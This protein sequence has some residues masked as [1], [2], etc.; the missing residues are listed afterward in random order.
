MFSHFSNCKQG[1]ESDGEGEGLRRERQKVG[2]TE[3]KGNR[4]LTAE[5]VSS[6]EAYQSQRLQQ[7]VNRKKET[8]QSRMK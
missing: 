5:G 6:T 4:K 1:K 3:I 7:N 8:N 2:L